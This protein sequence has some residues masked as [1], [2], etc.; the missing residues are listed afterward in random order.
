MPSIK[1]HTQQEALALNE[2]I[3]NDCLRTG[4][5][6]GGTDNY[7]IPTLEESTNLW[8]VP[9]LEGYEQFFTTAELELANEQSELQP[10][11]MDMAV[12]RKAMLT[13]LKDNRDL[14][15]TSGQ[16]I[17]QLQK[18]QTIKALL[19]VG[20]RTLAKSMLAVAEVDEV[21]TQERKDK[22]LAML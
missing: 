13:Y 20:A 6:Q 4:I 1:F 8:V 2:R 16:S 9:I 17:A 19:E 11:L 22:Y 3:T 18:F 21:F 7:C 14:N 15:L 12:C 10:L 5:W